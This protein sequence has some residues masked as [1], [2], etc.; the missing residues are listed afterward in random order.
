[1]TTL[2]IV[3]AVLLVASGASITR[4]QHILADLAKHIEQQEV[5]G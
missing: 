1:M 5:S 2:F 4:V 3:L